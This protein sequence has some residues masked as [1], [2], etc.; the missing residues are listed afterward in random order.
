MTTT[1]DPSLA[2][3]G[4]IIAALKADAQLTAIV[5]AA[6]I[7]PRKVPASP[8][9]PFIRL[10][11]LTATPLRLD[12]TDGAEV[13]GAVHCFVKAV[14][15]SIPD[16]EALAMTINSHVARVLDA[17]EDGAVSQA[18]VIEDGAEADAYHGFVQIGITAT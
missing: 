3:R 10:G 15:G 2:V 1:L 9:W 7:Y 13:T 17:L 8:T 5:P 11:V 4:Q 14:P 16:P 12:C 6:R 18:Q